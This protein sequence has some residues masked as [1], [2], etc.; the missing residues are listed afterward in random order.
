[1]ESWFRE[2]IW[3][4]GQ[5]IWSHKVDLAWCNRT[6]LSEYNSKV[7]MSTS[8]ND[9]EWVVVLNLVLGLLYVAASK[10]HSEQ[11]K[12]E[13]N[14][15]GRTVFMFLPCASPSSREKASSQWTR[16]HVVYQFT[17]CSLQPT[18]PLSVDE[19]KKKLATVCWQSWYWVLYLFVS[20]SVSKPA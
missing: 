11:R 7:A 17:F 3:S 15:L 14:R 16:G 9:W 5:L 1:M 19:I 18:G 6:L 2:K 12:E 4:R 10:T 13:L 8:N 20:V